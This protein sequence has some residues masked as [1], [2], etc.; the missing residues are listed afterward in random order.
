MKAASPPLPG[1]KKLY[2]NDHVIRRSFNALVFG[3]LISV[4]IQW[5]S[6]PMPNAPADVPENVSSQLAL[7]PYITLG[8]G[9]LS[10][11]GLCFLIRRYLLVKKILTHGETVKGL[12]E[13]LDVHLHE[14]DSNTTSPS[15]RTYRRFYHATIRYP[16]RGEEKK[17]RL[18]LPGSGFT[19]G[20]VK[21]RETDLLVL[22]SAPKKP[23]IRSVYFGKI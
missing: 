3:I 11:I 6:Q 14:N 1:L 20:L 7:T 15:T 16:W 21:G 10:V 2:W 23:L 4:G 9:V 22:N 18:R 12:V 13:S 8:G 5:A 17:V 19:Y